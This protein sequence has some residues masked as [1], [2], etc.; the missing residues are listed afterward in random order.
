MQIVIKLEDWAIK[1][2]EK[3]GVKEPK[4]TGNFRVMAGAIEVAKQSFNEQYGNKKIVFSSALMAEAE[5]LTEK[6]AAEITKQFT[7]GE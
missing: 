6:V 4:I 1:A 3:D 2:I 5:A 7:G